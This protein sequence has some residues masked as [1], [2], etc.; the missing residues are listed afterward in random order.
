M[1]L[2]ESNWDNDKFSGSH[3]LQ[4]TKVLTI[5]DPFYKERAEFTVVIQFS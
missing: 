2:N 1:W 3:K 4:I 5:R